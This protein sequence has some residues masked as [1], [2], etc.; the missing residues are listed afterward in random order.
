[1]LRPGGVLMLVTPDT[2]SLSRRLMG[3]GWSHYKAE[4][5]TYWNGELLDRVAAGAGLRALGRRSAVKSMSLGYLRTQLDTYAHP[6]LSPVLRAAS[7]LLRPW[8]TCLFAMP[9]GEFIAF[10]E[11]PE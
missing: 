9:M 3:A 8:S 4:H 11:R 7:R 1:L 2:R 10:Y 5:L 6:V